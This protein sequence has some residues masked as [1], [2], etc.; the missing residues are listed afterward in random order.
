[1][2]CAAVKECQHIS[3]IIHEEKNH[4]ENL[5]LNY[6]YCKRLPKLLQF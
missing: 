1:M 2:Q 4:R 6:K 5:I 3:E